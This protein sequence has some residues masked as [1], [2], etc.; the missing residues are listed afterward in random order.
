MCHFSFFSCS[1]GSAKAP[2][3]RVFQNVSIEFS[4][5]AHLVVKRSLKLFNVI[6]IHRR[7]HSILDVTSKRIHTIDVKIMRK[8]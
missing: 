4:P 8:T 7:K 5:S 6:I 3:A 2:P 1:R